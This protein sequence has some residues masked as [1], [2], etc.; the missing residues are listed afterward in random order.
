MEKNIFEHGSSS[1]KENLCY[2]EYGE[3][4]YQEDISL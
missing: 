3:S 1:N 4:R 2:Y